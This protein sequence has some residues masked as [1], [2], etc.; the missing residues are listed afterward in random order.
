M[1]VLTRKLGERVVIDDR[2]VI[3]VLDIKGSRVRLGIEA[4]PGVSILREE[5]RTLGINLRGET[6]FP[7]ERAETS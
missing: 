6:L 7:L 4:P 2:I 1:L 3:E 5:L